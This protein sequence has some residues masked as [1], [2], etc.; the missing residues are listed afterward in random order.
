[1]QRNLHLKSHAYLFNKL[2]MSGFIRDRLT[3][4]QQ[5]GQP[6]QA[7]RLHLSPSLFASCYVSCLRL[8]HCLA[9]IVSSS[10]LYRSCIS[11]IIVLPS[12]LE[13][14]FDAVG[15]RSILPELREWVQP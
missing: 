1:M 2:M 8:V 7:D 15:I 13:P 14:A 9:G 6:T 11:V 4:G 3:S 5:P 12:G 10:I